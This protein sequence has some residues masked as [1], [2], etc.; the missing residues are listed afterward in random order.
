MVLAWRCLFHLFDLEHL[1]S[2]ICLHYQ[3][4]GSKRIY[5]LSN[6]NIFF[7]LAEIN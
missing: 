4:E 1:H 5:S 2:C 6:A 7:V 3:I